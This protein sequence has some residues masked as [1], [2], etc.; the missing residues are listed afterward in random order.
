MPLDRLIES[1]AEPPRDAETLRKN[2][3]GLYVDAIDWSRE[4][5]TPVSKPS[6]AASTKPAT[7]ANL[8][9]GSPLAS[10]SSAL[11]QSPPEIRP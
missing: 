1:F 6:G 3:L 4:M 11:A 9:V 7:S 2:P 5:D 8:P 10:Q